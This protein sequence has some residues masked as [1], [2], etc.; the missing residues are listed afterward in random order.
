MLTIYKFTCI[1]LSMTADIEKDEI[2]LTGVMSA[3]LRELSKINRPFVGL[4][5]VKHFCTWMY[6]SNNLFGKKSKFRLYSFN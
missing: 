2:E 1:A 5:F 3:E 6:A 4:S